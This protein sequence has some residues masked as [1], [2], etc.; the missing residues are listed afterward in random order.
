MLSKQSGGFAFWSGFYCTFTAPIR[1]SLIINGAGE[2][3]R[4]LVS[5][6]LSIGGEG[7]F[8]TGGGR[9]FAFFF[10]FRIGPSGGRKLSFAR[11][12]LGYLVCSDLIVAEFEAGG[13]NRQE[14][15]GFFQNTHSPL[16]PPPHKPY[17]PL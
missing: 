8:S 1:K 7:R 16:P 5:A 17:G 13:G 6:C 14:G 4:T 12:V 15:W 9:K 10:D 2:G 11:V 3:T